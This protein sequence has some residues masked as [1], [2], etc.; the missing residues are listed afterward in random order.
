M[1][2]I[3]IN[4]TSTEAYLLATRPIVLRKVAAARRRVNVVTD[5]V[6]AG[7]FYG[8]VGT[9]ILLAALVAR[10][11]GAALRVITRSES[12]RA[13][14]DGFLLTYGIEL[15]EPI[16][17]AFS[18]FYDERVAIDAHEGEK[19][20][21]TSWWTTRS[22]SGS[23]GSEP[24]V[25]L[26]QEDERMFY[27]AGGEQD[28]CSEVLADEKLAFVVNSELLFEHLIQ[29]GLGNV[30]RNGTWFEPAFPP[31][32]FARNTAVE[33]TKHTLMFYARPKNVRN[34]FYF[35]LEVLEASFAR[36]VIDRDAWSVVF[37][38]KDI[39]KVSLNSG[40][41]HP[42]LMENLSWTDYAALLGTVD[43]GLSL[44]YTPHPSYPPLDL[45]ASGAV[46]V[47]N[48]FANKRDLGNYS[49]NIIC[50]DLDVESMLDA[51]RKGVALALDQKTR[52]ANHASNGLGT[53]WLQSLAEVVKR[54]SQ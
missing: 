43:L 48:R 44:M 3:K 9:A 15:P 35:G 2:T 54:L 50:G 17:Y 22:V 51:M 52:R 13:R 11:T 25:Y 21:T 36:G 24:V 4:E 34:L 38:G 41:V 29:S 16:E 49:K 46:C 5:S 6:N 39:P 33:K 1:A 26:L 7:S 12:A 30:G 28:M 53:D 10:A 40:A 23:V 8:G 19:Y 27:E 42:V 47:T 37:V 31:S 20:I 18:P 32:L 14:L 45:A